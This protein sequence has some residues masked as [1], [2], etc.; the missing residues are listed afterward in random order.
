MDV[1]GK[2]IVLNKISARIAVQKLRITENK[3]CEKN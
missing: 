1:K 2:K 3:M